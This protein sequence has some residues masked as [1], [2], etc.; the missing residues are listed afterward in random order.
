MTV[1]INGRPVAPEQAVLPVLDHGLLYGDG[2]FEGIRAYGGKVFRLKAHLDRLASGAK[3]LMLELPL[4]LDEL[5]EQV[6]RAVAQEAAAGNPDSYIRLLATR[7]VGPLGLDPHGCGKP[8]LVVI[9]DRIQL[10]PPEFYRDGVSVASSS[11]R[12]NAPDSLDPR[13]KGLNYLNNIL[14]KIQARQAGAQEAILLNHQGYVAECTGDNI[15]C[16]KAGRLRVPAAH[17]GALEGITLEAVLGLAGD[18]GIPVERATMT[19]YDL[20]TADELFLTGTGAELVPVCRVDGRPLPPDGPVFRRL[21]A[22]F[23]RRVK[24]AP[25]WMD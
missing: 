24:E 11:M 5:A 19:L 2:I 22:E 16:V 25:D 23:T 12:R 21:R 17:L 20:Y 6:R 1:W 8:N 7:G 14:A 15:V 9:V 18:L 4:G 10:Y 3:A 13:V